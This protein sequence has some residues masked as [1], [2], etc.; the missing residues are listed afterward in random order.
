MS[1]PG[2]R[3]RL[4]PSLRHGDWVEHAACLGADRTVFFAP[5]SDVDAADRARAV[6]GRCPVTEEC[7]DYAL[8]N[9][10]TEGIWAGLDPEQRRALTRRPRT[11]RQ[12]P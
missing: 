6:C 10:M 1:A 5:P 3:L 12:E 2:P 11:T 7:L 9:Q 4:R 8:T